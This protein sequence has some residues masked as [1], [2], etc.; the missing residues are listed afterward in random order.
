MYAGDFAELILLSVDQ[1]EKLPF[2]MNVGVG[3]DRTVNDYYRIT[4]KLLN[5]KGNFKHD[6]SKPTGMKQKLLDISLQRSFGWL[7]KTSLESGIISTYNSFI[8]S[9]GR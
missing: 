2:E 9:T 6:L 4:S 5:Y 7:P 8:E 1:F 3:Y